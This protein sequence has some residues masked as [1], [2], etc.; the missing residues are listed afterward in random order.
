MAMPSGTAKTLAR[1][2]PPS[3]R[4]TVMPMSWMKPYSVNSSQPSL[5]IVMG[6]AR[7]VGDT[8]PPSVNAAQTATNRMKKPT[9]SSQRAR[10]LTGSRGTRRRRRP[11]EVAGVAG[12]SAG[13][14]A[15]WVVINQIRI[16]G[17]RGVARRRRDRSHTLG[18]AAANPLLYKA[19]VKRDGVV[20]GRLADDPGLE[21]DLGRLLHEFGQFACKEGLVCRAILPAQEP[22]RLLELLARL[23]DCSTHDFVG[24]FRVR[25]DHFQGLE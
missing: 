5:T 17:E 1:M 3:T 6:L 16:A 8:K 9:P 25:L 15:E 4:Q 13:A 21:Q 22:G 7:K 20:F 11:G 24:L 19:C 2:K 18:R 10:A 14:C 23:L 12:A